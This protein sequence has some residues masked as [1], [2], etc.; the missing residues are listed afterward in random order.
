[1]H[2]E[3]SSNLERVW[4][5][6]FVGDMP[7][8][9]TLIGHVDGTVTITEDVPN[10][11]TEPRHVTIGGTTKTIDVPA[12]TPNLLVANSTL[13]E[14]ADLL[15]LRHEQAQQTKL[16]GMSDEQRRQAEQRQAN[17]KNY[18]Q[19]EQRRKAAT[20]EHTEDVGPLDQ[21]LH[22]H[23]DNMPTDSLLTPDDIHAAAD[24]HDI[25]C[26]RCKGTG[27]AHKLTCSC[28]PVTFEPEYTSGDPDPDCAECGGKGWTDRGCGRCAATGWRR[29]STTAQLAAANGNTLV[30]V[31]LDA[32]AFRVVRTHRSGPDY[33]GNTQVSHRWQLS[34]THHR[35]V[36]QQ[37][38]LP[39]DTDEVIVEA[40][41][42]AKPFSGLR[43]AATSGRH[44]PGPTPAAFVWAMLRDMPG[45]HDPRLDGD[46]SWR[47]PTAT[48]LRHEPLDCRYDTHGRV[49][50]R[51][52]TVRPVRS[53]DETWAEIIEGA[54][55]LQNHQDDQ[56]TVQVWLNTGFIAT[57]EHGPQL[58]IVVLQPNPYV[59]PTGFMQ[60]LGHGLDRTLESAVA[61]L[62][63]FGFLNS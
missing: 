3:P 35:N 20:T 8:Q 63:R 15:D 36:L 52:I 43:H 45:G 2:Q 11:N 48:E 59:R 13:P 22:D 58:Q 33:S 1:M 16:E 9:R 55:A 4:Q 21:W 60:E 37:L 19:R 14:A 56:R 17:W 10:G 44:T 54:S 29:T 53:L 27:R 40:A 7:G 39:E 47:N 49:S 57:G 30:D 46:L 41:G 42:Q 26:R 5:R 12:T 18:N 38:G 28:V 62:R 6:L 24:G 51:V 50:H 31:P 23:A 32:S 34:L 61:R 25:P